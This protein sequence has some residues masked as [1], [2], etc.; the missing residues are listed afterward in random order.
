M[1]HTLLVMAALVLA[2]AAMLTDRV[3]AEIRKAGVEAIAVCFLHSYA[4]PAHERRVGEKLKQT[5]PDAFV[6]LSVDILPEIREY[7]RTSTSVVN[8][9]VGPILSRYLTRLEK[10]DAAS[11]RRIMRDNGLE[12]LS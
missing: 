3:I 1:D 11:E 2:A 9:Y 6:T 8:A 12:L 10:L 7:E 5:F 4:N